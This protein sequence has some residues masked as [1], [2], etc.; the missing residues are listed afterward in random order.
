MRTYATAQLIGTRSTQ[1]DATAVYTTPTG[2]RAYALLDGIGSD[3]SIREW[4]RTAARRLART[5]A[6]CGNAETGL[7]RVYDHYAADPERQDEYMRQYMPSAAAVVAVTAPGQP[8]TLAWSGDSRA[9]LLD[10]GIAAR[11]T[12]DHN[13]RRIFP[14]TATNPHSGNRNVITSYLG[15]T[16]TDEE[17]TNHYNHPAIET[18]TVR[19]KRPVR[20]LLASDGA[21]EPHEDARHDLYA[22]LDLDSP[23]EAAR[24]FVRLAV[25]TSLDLDGRADNATVLLADLH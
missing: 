13:L 17:A 9:Y 23:A 8:L 11:L 6:R 19:I 10:R 1:C 22:E 24:D 2:A 4:T 16:F 5:A 25:D 15:N 21:Y 14:P 20:L 7:R 12:D 18:K 3:K